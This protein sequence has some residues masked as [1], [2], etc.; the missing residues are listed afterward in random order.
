MAGVY[1]CKDKGFVSFCAIFKEDLMK[2]GE[3]SN[4]EGNGYD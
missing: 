4:L 3:L 2:I 1:F